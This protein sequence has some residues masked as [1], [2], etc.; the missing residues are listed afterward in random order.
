MIDKICILIQDYYIEDRNCLLVQPAKVDMA[1]GEGIYDNF[2]YKT[3]TGKYISGQFA[4]YNSSKN[5]PKLPYIVRVN[6]KGMAITYN[7]AMIQTNG[8]HNF[9]SVTELE[10][11]IINQK[12][13]SD[14]KSKGIHFN[15]NNSILA[16]IDLAKDITANHTFENYN[17]FFRSL[18]AKRDKK[19][20]EYNNGFLWGNKNIEFCAYDKIMALIEKLKIAPS[21]LGLENINNIIRGELRLL[22]SESIR[23]NLKVNMLG[24]IVRAGIYENL[25]IK[26]KAI[27]KDL[28]FSAKKENII[29]IEIFEDII[30]EFKRL[31]EIAPNKAPLWLLAT[32]NMN[33]VTEIIKNSEDFMSIS[34][35]AGYKERAAYNHKKLFEDLKANTII[36]DQTGK[37]TYSDLYQEIYK[38]LVA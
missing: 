6:F 1:T 20:T 13:E 4:E 18:N 12:I 29:Q 24:D 27:V 33:N 34:Q 3:D 38:K 17:S 31:K 19:K 15:I 10:L 22:K 11:R 37:V 25:A 14:L 32:L 2:L 5:N 23:R 21:L 28:I 8:V 26:Y 36:H 7:P 9:Y 35:A 30:K 16:R